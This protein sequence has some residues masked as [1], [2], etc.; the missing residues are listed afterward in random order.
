MDERDLDFRLNQITASIGL[1]INYKIYKVFPW[2][3]PYEYMSIGIYGGYLDQVNQ[4]P[5]IYSLRNRLL[6]N[7]KILRLV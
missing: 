6:T 3:H 4:K 7:D 2:M 1:R 5:W